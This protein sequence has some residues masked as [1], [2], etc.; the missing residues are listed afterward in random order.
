MALGLI[1]WMANGIMWVEFSGGVSTRGSCSIA[2][3]IGTEFEVRHDEK[4]WMFPRVTAY[5]WSLSDAN[6]SSL[7]TIAGK[8]FSI[9]VKPTSIRLHEIHLQWLTTVSQARLF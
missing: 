4:G 2:S 5:L 3:L 8:G 6:Q 9:M 7:G 1:N